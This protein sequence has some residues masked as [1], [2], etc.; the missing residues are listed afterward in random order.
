[1]K[2]EAPLRKGVDGF[3]KAVVLKNNVKRPLGFESRDWGSLLGLS[4][5]GE[6]MMYI[7]GLFESHKGRKERQS[8]RC[9][10]A[11]ML[12]AMY[13]VVHAADIIRTP[14]R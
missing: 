1:V 11:H 12:D 2:K 13:A 4:N 8:R 7:A 3:V 10:I 14:R 9:K 6:E 5:K